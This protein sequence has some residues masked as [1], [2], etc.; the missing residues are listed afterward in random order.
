MR[1]RL[2]LAVPPADYVM[3]GRVEGGKCF[4]ELFWDSSL[5]TAEMGGHESRGRSTEELLP[6]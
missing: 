2:P 1:E 6:Y 3:A 4:R 5:R